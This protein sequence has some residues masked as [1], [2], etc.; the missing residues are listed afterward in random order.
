[1]SKLQTHIDI[2]SIAMQDLESMERY[3][4]EPSYYESYRHKYITEHE[5]HLKIIK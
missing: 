1:M 2:M 3:I 4:I 5:P